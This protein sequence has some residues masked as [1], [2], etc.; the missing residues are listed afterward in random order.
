MRIDKRADYRLAAIRMYTILISALSQLARALIILD[1]IL[2]R[3]CR[4]FDG[5]FIRLWQEHL[6]GHKTQACQQHLS[7]IM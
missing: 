4:R 7:N 1:G 2:Y 5:N 6:L 3:H